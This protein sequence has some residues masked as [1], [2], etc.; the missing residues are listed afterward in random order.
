MD[1]R[2]SNL[3]LALG[4]LSCGRGVRE[5]K[6]RR[7]GEKARVVPEEF[8]LHSVN[9]GGGQ[10]KVGGHGNKHAGDTAGWEIVVQCIYSVCEEKHGRPSVGIGSSVR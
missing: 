1:E 10:H 8:T 4:I 3:L 6:G 2:P 9:I 7:E 5:M